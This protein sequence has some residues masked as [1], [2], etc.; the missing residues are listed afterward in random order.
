MSSST[1][2][3]KK[4]YSMPIESILTENPGNYSIAV[5]DAKNILKKNIWKSC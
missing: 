3:D 4:Y 2:L 5:N 1:N